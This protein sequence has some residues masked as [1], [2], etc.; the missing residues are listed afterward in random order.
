[1]NQE[2]HAHEF[3]A[4]IRQL[5]DIVVHS[6]YT[7]REI[8]LRE[9]ISN[10]SDAMEKWRHMLAV[11]SGLADPGLALE[12]RLTAD[13]SAGTLVIEDAGIGMD[14]E[15]LVGHLGTIAHS[16]TRRFLEAA[17]ERGTKP[18]G[19]IGQFGVGFYAAFMVA[20][21]VE[22]F[23]RS[24]REGSEGL[25]WASDGK[26]GYTIAPAE[27]APARGTRIV[28][29]LKED[30]KEFAREYRIRSLVE[31]YS[32]F[33]G[34]PVLL[35][36][37]R[38]NEVEALWLKN[39]SEVTEEQYTAFYK[40]TARAMDEPVYRLH[41]SADAPID[42]NALVFVPGENPERTGFGR[43]DPG[44]ALYCRKI[45]IDHQPPGL[46][47]EWMRFLKGV[48]DSQ[49]LPLNI[50]RETMQDSALVRKIGGV[51]AGRVVRMLEN[52]AKNDPAKYLT[53]HKRFHRF[54]K[55]GA[56]TDYGHRDALAKLL[57]FEST[58]EDADKACGFEDY[59]RRAREGQESIYYLVGPSRAA[60]EASPYLEAFRARG[61][62]VLLCT[63]GIDEVVMESLVEFDGKKLIPAA[64][65]GLDLGGSAQEGETLDKEQGDALCAYLQETLG[66]RVARV[67]T[68]E[69]LVESPAVALIPEDAMTANMKHMMR[70]MQ[71]DF[72]ADDKI[73][74]EINPR[75]ALI[76]KLATARE[77]DPETAGL[78]AAQLLDNALMAA[79]LLEDARDTVAR[80][81]KLMEKAIG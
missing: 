49:D 41:F 77:N 17:K 59:V 71:A 57:R 53:F 36:D 32:N 31:T 51:I 15:E 8:F 7:E 30:A 20:D 69:R 58:H 12:V 75:H 24:W 81:N 65:A 45:L 43:V 35:N 6:L 37:N 16:G 27:D 67:A 79:G 80:M 44:V 73:E 74:L 10:A 46:L 55:E 22:V 13:E 4:E 23:T 78:V 54:L 63:D 9:L 33:V 1:M 56:V 76:R 34:Y 39:K 25:C 68:G 64:R 21:K 61:I 28:L 19:V 70:A 26:G 29:T 47:P 66:A 18:E 38:L 72:K 2:T 14:R 48:I 60:L 50:S 42:L 11:E 3:Q 52:E 62:E 40:F 5:L